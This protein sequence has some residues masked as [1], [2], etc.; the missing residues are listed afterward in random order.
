MGDGRVAK[1]E[2]PGDRGCGG[3]GARGYAD[4]DDEDGGED[5]GEA[6][7]GEKADALES[8]DG[9]AESDDEGGEEGP[10]GEN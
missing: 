6:G 4:D 5:G 9:G 7:P 1:V 3:P 8:A 10:L 2:R